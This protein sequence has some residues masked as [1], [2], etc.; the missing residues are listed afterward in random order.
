VV[1]EVVSLERRVRAFSE[2]AAEPPVTPSRLDVNSAVQ[3]RVA[4]LR[5]AHP[6][7]TYDAQLDPAR[8]CA[9]AD[10]DLIKGVLTNLM[11]NAADAARSGGVVMIR[12]AMEKDR[13]SIEVHDNGPGLSAQARTSIFEPT[14]SFK[15]N[16][17]GLGLSI[18]RKSA[19]LCGGDVMLIPGELGGA[20]FRVLL[21]VAESEEVAR[22]S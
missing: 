11:E 13:V 1:D 15:K 10:P 7:V 5:A 20:G 9:M 17:M 22:A 14:I 16:G 12:T 8:P 19:L 21:P 3:E 4:F 18:A 2:L 6:E